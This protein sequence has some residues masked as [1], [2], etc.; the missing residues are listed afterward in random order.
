[1]SWSASPSKR[2]C[3]WFFKRVL[4]PGC[5]YSLP[6]LPAE[7][8]LED[9]SST[10]VVA[11]DEVLH[12]MAED[13][14]YFEIV[15]TNLRRRKGPQTEMARARQHMCFAVS[16]QMYSVCDASSSSADGATLRPQGLPE[17]RDLV[18]F[19][20][21]PL[22]RG[23]LRLLPQCQAS[24]P[25][26]VRTRA[27]VYLSRRQW[28]LTHADT[29]CV[30]V[31]EGLV[32]LGWCVGRAVRAHT[33]TS[34]RIF[35]WREVLSD[36]PYWQCLVTLEK[37]F[38]KGLLQ[39]R[40]G[41]PQKYYTLILESTLPQEVPVFEDSRAYSEWH[42]VTSLA[43]SSCQL[44]STSETPVL[45]TPMCT[46]R[47]HCALLSNSPMRRVVKRPRDETT[48]LSDQLAPD[49]PC[50]QAFTFGDS[51]AAEPSVS[52]AVDMLADDAEM[53]RVNIAHAPAS[54][55][56][57]PGVFS[58]VE[59]H[60]VRVE[61][62]GVAGQAGYYRRVFVTCQMHCEPGHA[63]CR[64]RRNTGPRQTRN[65]GVQEPLAYLGAWLLAGREL[66]TREEHMALK[67][68]ESQTREYALLQ[69][70]L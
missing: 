46:A 53:S 7:V 50:A 5:V 23:A 44:P 60:V 28:D 41:M 37:L 17:I 22:W 43:D 6:R 63:P 47:R 27:P 52:L 69:N 3:K 16:L 31:L 39:L 30:A 62:R 51:A 56:P 54:A 13:I 66:A 20:P 26:C 38:D 55:C 12:A 19:A 34:E 1:M 70:W 18:D 15:D 49:V 33:R 14:L 25:G 61:E 35:C 32:D 4:T 2:G 65:F 24:L 64:I 48:L 59:G 29:P 9:C 21:W 67:P 45:D 8:P 40:T 42:P 58:Y 36:K 10:Q 11:A 57:Q 68:S